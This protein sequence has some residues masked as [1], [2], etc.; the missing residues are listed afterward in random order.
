M[1]NIKLED[2]SYKCASKLYRLKYSGQKTG[3]GCGGGTTSPSPPPGAYRVN[4]FTKVKWL[5]QNS[6]L[7]LLQFDIR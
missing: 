2:K 5:P 3:R 6:D 1:F 4:R 7:Q